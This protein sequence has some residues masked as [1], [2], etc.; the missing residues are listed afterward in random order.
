MPDLSPDL[1]IVIP[2]R[3]EAGNVAD[4]LHEIAT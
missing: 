2:M 1:S 3:N 4:L